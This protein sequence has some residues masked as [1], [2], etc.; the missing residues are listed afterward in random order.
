[1]KCLIPAWNFAWN[2]HGIEWNKKKMDIELLEEIKK[3][4]LHQSTRNYNDRGFRSRYGLPI[5]VVLEIFKKCRSIT[6]E[7]DDDLELPQKIP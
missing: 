1:M 7:L 4:F 3:I 6:V 5:A 2:N